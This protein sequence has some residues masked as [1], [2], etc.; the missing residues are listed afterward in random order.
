MLLFRRKSASKDKGVY[1]KLLVGIIL[2]KV[3]MD[4]MVV[5]W[6]VFVLIG[7]SLA[8]RITFIIREKNSLAK[9]GIAKID[10]MDGKTF[11]KCLEVLFRQMGYRVQRTKYTGDFGADLIVSKDGT[12]HAVQAKRYS[13]NVGVKA[14]QEAVASKG[15]YKCQEAL[16]VTNSY[17]TNSAKRLAKAN[18]VEL[19]D[20]KILISK[21]LLSNKREKVNDGDNVLKVEHENC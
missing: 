14:I 16:V 7:L 11:E 1:M 18:S 3:I 20:R 6:P 9:S 19:W 10:S 5:A 17:F 13:D 8:A 21:L 12:K 4:G 15:Y 2:A